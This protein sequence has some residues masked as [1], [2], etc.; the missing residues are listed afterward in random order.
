M[1]GGHSLAAMLIAKPGIRVHSFDLMRWKYSRPVMKLLR[2]RF[3]ANIS[4]HEGYSWKSLKP[5]VA[6]A[7]QS[8]ERCDL[9][10]LDGGRTEAAARKDIDLLER[11]AAPGAA[12]VVDD[13]D[14]GPGPALRRAAKQRWVHILESYH[15]EKHTE[16]SPCLRQS[17]FARSKPL[18]APWGFAIAR[19]IPKR[20]ARGLLS[21][22]LD[23]D[24]FFRTAFDSLRPGDVPIFS[25][26]ASKEQ[27]EEDRIARFTASA[28]V[29]GL[30]MIPIGKETRWPAS[31]TFGGGFKLLATKYA[32]VA[33]RLARRSP[34]QVA[35]MMD[36]QD[37]FVQA[38][39]ET[40]VRRFR[41]AGR[42]IVVGLET[43]CPPSRCTTPE[44][45]PGELSNPVELVGI[46]N[47]THI[48]GGIVIGEAA[49][50]KTM[51]EYVATHTFVSIRDA[52]GRTLSRHS[53]QKGIGAFVNAH[54]SMV[55]FDRTQMLAA[56]IN[57]NGAVG[58]EPEFRRYY[59]IE[60]LSTP[61]NRSGLLVRRHIVNKHTRKAPCFVHIPGSQEYKRD[62]SGGKDLMRVFDE[63][64]A[65]LVPEA[66]RS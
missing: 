11:V 2:S 57:E 21:D 18:C 25:V 56:I 20:L 52:T 26:A 33:D 62:W 32:E 9:M 65:T 16:H 36:S 29:W 61:R 34:R 58:H 44:P 30:H 6:L 66:G 19:Y 51:W 38:S 45:R 60:Q 5:F 24:A 28:A 35:I 4:F 64:S 41:D 22:D 15:V 46:A 13:I 59:A 40:V 53:A 10:L 63:I 23:R 54:P 3:G 7:E 31:G 17:M 37:A 14:L 39:A 12:L 47:L 48:N 27:I 43:G 49:A 50:L 1:N 55:A 8:G 42:P